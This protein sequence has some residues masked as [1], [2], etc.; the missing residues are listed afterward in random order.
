LTRVIFVALI[1]EA[2]SSRYRDKI[3]W[4]SS[5][6]RKVLRRV[7]TMSIHIMMFLA[8]VYKIHLYNSIGKAID[9]KV[10]GQIVLPCA[11]ADNWK[12]LLTQSR[13]SA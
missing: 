1:R 6:C 7:K 3:L 11:C 8:N 9:R 5:M 2:R 13:T 12:L 4:P 10:S